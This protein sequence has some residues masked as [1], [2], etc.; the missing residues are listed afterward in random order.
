MNNKA[1]IK[2]AAADIFNLMR[3]QISTTISSR[4]YRLSQKQESRI[5]RLTFTYNFG[6]GLI[7]VA[8]ERLKDSETEQNRVQSGN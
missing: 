4:D 5:F 6:N 3:P 2:F 1:N 7:K 8:R